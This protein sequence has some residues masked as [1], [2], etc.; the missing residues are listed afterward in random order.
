MELAD[1]PDDLRL[2]LQRAVDISPGRPVLVD[3]YIAGK[4]VEVDAVSDG[5]DVLIPAIMEH[6]ERTGV[7]SGDSIAIWP[8]QSLSPVAQQKV[9]EYTRKISLALGVIGLINLQFVVVGD[10]VYVLEANLRSSRTVPFI[11]KVTGIPLVKLAIK[12]IL[13]KP[14]ISLGYPMLPAPVKGLVAAKAPVFSWSKINEADT[15]LGPEMRSTGE[16]IGIGQDLQQALYK[17]FLAMGFGGLL[18]FSSHEGLSALITVA[19][20][21]KE[22]VV[23]LAKTLVSYGF[24]VYATDGTWKKLRSENIPAQH[25]QKIGKGTPDIMDLI[26]QGQVSVV[27]NTYTKGRIPHRDGYRIRRIAWDAGIPCLSSLDTAYA[28]A[29][30]LGA[31]QAADPIDIST[32]VRPIPRPA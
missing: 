23:P 19:D 26:T 8:C 20:R 30:A 16:V 3:K 1:G 6:V 15:H 24:S 18:G 4:E 25:V 11:T 5:R 13:G 17:A 10:E 22:Q 7:H 21:D 29:D 12:A 31:G 28:L 32:L 14:L 9:A 27:I 2:Y